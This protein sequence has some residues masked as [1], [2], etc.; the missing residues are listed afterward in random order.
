MKTNSLWKTSL[1]GVCLLA[2]WQADAK[3]YY[4]APGGTGNGMAIDKPFGDPIKA[5]AA[6]KAGDILYV[7]GGTYHLSKTINVT[8]T[9][10]ADQRICVFAYPGDTERPIFDFSGQPRSTSTEASTYR[11]I[12][13]KIGAN[14]WHYRGLDI[15]NSADNGMKLEGSYCVVELCRFY[16]NG[17]T[18]LQQGFGK[19][20]NGN[21]T[22]NQE[23]KYGRYNLASVMAYMS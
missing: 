8:Q 10:T 9:G 19:D 16:G 13:H 15:C 4:L 21:N 5:F 7:R 18:G 14:Y 6:L 11:G 2:S 3:D 12:M 1:I 22:R 23:Y 20:G 17:D